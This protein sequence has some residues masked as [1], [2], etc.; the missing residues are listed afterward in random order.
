MPTAVRLAHNLSCTQAAVPFVTL[1]NRIFWRSVKAFSAWQCLE[2]VELTSGSA[3]VRTLLPAK[4]N[5]VSRAMSG[6]RVDL[7]DQLHQAGIS[8]VG[9]QKTRCTRQVTGS[10]WGFGVFAAAVDKAGHGGVELWIRQDIMGDP[11]SFH[12]LVAEPRFPWLRA[13]RGGGHPV[14]CVSWA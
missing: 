1:A 10:C 6:R 2:V 11:R 13:H 3:N 5:A 7:A 8:V 9:T 14:L 12:V 4:R